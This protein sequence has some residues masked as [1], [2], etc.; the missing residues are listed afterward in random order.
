M[1]SERNYSNR[2]GPGEGYHQGGRGNRQQQGSSRF[3]QQ[4][5]DMSLPNMGFPFAAGPYMGMHMGGFGPY[6]SF[7]G[8]MPGVMGYGGGGYGMMPPPGAPPALASTGPLG[9]PPG[10]ING[11]PPSQGQVG[12]AQ[13]LSHKP[14][15]PTAPKPLTHTSLLETN[16]YA[17]A[18]AHSMPGNPPMM[19]GNGNGNG[20]NSTPNFQPP[21]MQQMNASFGAQHTQGVPGWGGGKNNSRF[22]T[23]G[24]NNHG[25]GHGHNSLPEFER[26]TLKCTGIP[27]HVSELELRK[28]FKQFGRIVLLQLNVNAGAGAGADSAEKQV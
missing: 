1:N 4:Q 3:P 15:P 24:N 6:G 20:N 8:P 23:E 25:H 11:Q 10:V 5:M 22:N 27:A 28:H 21:Q 26:F 19:Y 17:Q 16:V 13:M 9:Y 12:G 18:Q 7:P 2:G 14:A